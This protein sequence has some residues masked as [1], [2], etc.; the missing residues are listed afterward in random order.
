MAAISSC[1]RGGLALAIYETRVRKAPVIWQQLSQRPGNV[2]VGIALLIMT[3][4]L[5]AAAVF[6]IIVLVAIINV[7]RAF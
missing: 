6:V 4:F 7:L 5:A 2:A 3:L 1:G